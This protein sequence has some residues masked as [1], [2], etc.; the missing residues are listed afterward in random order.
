MKE[1]V[2]VVI[3]DADE[4]S[5]SSLG[6]QLAAHADLRVTGYALGV[7]AAVSLVAETRPDVIIV[8]VTSLHDDAAVLLAEL[9]QFESSVRPTTV[10]LTAFGH[11][12]VTQ[13][14][15]DLGADFYLLKPPGPGVL[16]DRVRR[17]ADVAA[18]QQAVT[19]ADREWRAAATSTMLRALGVPA[20]IKGYA[21]LREAVVAC[22]G[23]P[24][25][26]DAVTK[27]LYP[28]VA[29]RHGTTAA[30]V[31]RAVRHAVDVAW[32]QG[33]PPAAADLFGGGSQLCRTRPCNSALIAGL[34][35]LL[36]TGSGP[37]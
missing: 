33:P 29:S 16:A 2:L 35:D 31:E 20:H 10:I 15:V 36:V 9:R 8:D 3:A 25:L 7:S 12:Q 4:A 14:C 30:R 27:E 18:A 13:R 22:A 5:A 28:L 17:L 6:R 23:Q 34:A 11:E 32:R 21:Y 24:S 1:P 37:G 19:V 26:L